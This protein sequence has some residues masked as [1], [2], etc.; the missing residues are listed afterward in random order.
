MCPWYD[1]SDV[2][3]K[4]FSWS[5]GLKKVV[6]NSKHTTLFHFGYVWTDGLEM[7]GMEPN[8]IESHQLPL[9]GVFKIGDTS[10][11]LSPVQDA[12]GWN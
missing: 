7:D 6:L 5:V 8:W 3:L 11:F 10:I 12:I 9:F 4:Q 1:V 2:K